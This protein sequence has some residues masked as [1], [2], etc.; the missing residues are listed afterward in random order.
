M[1]SCYTEEVKY[2]AA[3]DLKSF[4]A[5][6]ECVERGLDPLKTNLVVADK[7]RTDKTICL[8]VSPSL[9]SFGIP[10]RPRLFEVVQKVKEANR[11]RTNL[12]RQRPF[13]GRSIDLD[14]LNDHYELAIDYIVAKPR[15]AFYMAYSQK[16]YET[17]LKYIAPEDI[18]VY[19][20]DEVFIDLTPYLKTYQ[21]KPE[22][23][24][25]FLIKEV[26]YKT[27]ITATAGI[28]TNL[29]LAKIAMDIV[30]KHMTADKNGVRMAYLDEEKYRRTLWEH[31][32]ISDFWRVGKGYMRRLLDLG[33]KNM[34]D[35]A[36]LSLEKEDLLYR[37]FGVSAELLIDHAWGV[38]P[39][40]IKDIKS[41]VPEAKS[42]GSSQVLKEPYSY[43]KATLVL[44]EMAESLANDLKKRHLVSEHL[45]LY[46]GY[47]A[48]NINDPDLRERYTGEVKSDRYGREVPRF[49]HSSGHLE[50]P[51]SNSKDFIALTLKIF[52][53]IADP[54][55]YIR[56]LG[57]SAMDLKKQGDVR[58]ETISLFDDVSEVLKDKKEND[59]VEKAMLKVKAKF[60]KNAIM[61]MRDL[62]KGATLL[63][64]NEQIGGHHS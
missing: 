7:E 60:G 30:A 45:T 18:H 56:K 31:E 53:K 13:K 55:L 20:I 25:M 12:N 37:T 62:E 59:E 24:T 63:E 28:G 42:L 3:I 41:Y 48:I 15:M 47:D 46:V 8:A 10:G 26:L 43:Q 44:K 1:T 27:G 19:S 38:E 11:K 16:V 9:K 34:G 58:Y 40:T 23:L 29:Y 2:Y 32:P 54:K 64:R 35:I 49:A 21:M 52:E 33:L 22:E 36:L 51:S 57:L 61:R 14:E 5:S 50:N 6:V 39:V 4:Y 17:Y